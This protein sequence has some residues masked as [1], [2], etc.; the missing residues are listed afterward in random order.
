MGQ[1]TTDADD[2]FRDMESPGSSVPH[3]PVKSEI[4]DLFATI[5]EEVE[6]LDVALTDAQIATRRGYVTWVAM[7]ADASQPAGTVGEV[8][9]S[10]AGT[11]TDPVVG[12]T[13]NNSGTFLYSTSPAGW[14]RIGDYAVTALA[15]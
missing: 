9:T 1:I 10:D 2:V 14:R 5:D 8:P 4:R 13:V 11:H 15:S 3:E 6:A 7:A 12:G